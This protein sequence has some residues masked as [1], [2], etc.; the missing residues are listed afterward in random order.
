[1]EVAVMGGGCFWCV[2]ALLQRLKGVI[3]TCP[4]Y[5]G[6]EDENPSYK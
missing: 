5:C 4:G 1:M 3:R 6:G 2:E